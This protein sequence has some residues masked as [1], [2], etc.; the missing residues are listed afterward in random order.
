MFLP[1]P[2]P[3]VPPHSPFSH[4]RQRSRSNPKNLIHG[5]VVR[6]SIN[7]M[8]CYSN[9]TP[10]SVRMR[11][12]NLVVITTSAIRLSTLIST[13]A[14]ISMALLT[15]TLPVSLR[16]I[17]ERF[18]SDSIFCLACCRVFFFHSPRTCLS[19]FLRYHYC[20]LPNT[21]PYCIFICPYVSMVYILGSNSKF[22]RT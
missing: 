1:P 6:I 14:S 18:L 2:R 19:F 12:W 11:R 16:I 3:P 4:P 10:S 8:R 15:T 20:Y 9:I 17:S 21:L 22:Y 7:P 13:T 5:L